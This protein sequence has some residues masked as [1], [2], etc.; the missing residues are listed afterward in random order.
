MVC[1]QKSVHAALSL[2]TSLVNM[3]LSLLSSASVAS[4]QPAQSTLDFVLID[5]EERLPVDGDSVGHSDPTT[6]Q[7]VEGG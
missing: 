1:M 2:T 3:A 7:L 4:A 5:L 6:C